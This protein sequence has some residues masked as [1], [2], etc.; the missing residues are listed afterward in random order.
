MNNMEIQKLDENILELT[1][2]IEMDNPTNKQKYETIKPFFDRLN[3]HCNEFC[4][5]FEKDTDL[6]AMPLDLIRGT[7]YEEEDVFIP[8]VQTKQSPACL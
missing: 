6:F 3:I 2:L 7:I 5:R 4:L 8:A 1:A